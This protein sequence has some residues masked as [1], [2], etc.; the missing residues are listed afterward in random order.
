MFGKCIV[1]GVKVQGPKGAFH[2]SC[3]SAFT[4][5]IRY[6]VQENFIIV[7]TD[8][9]PVQDTGDYELPSLYEAE[10]TRLHISIPPSYRKV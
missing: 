8:I 3:E 9:E 4:M 10:P 1:C 5:G 2:R 7:T 6:E